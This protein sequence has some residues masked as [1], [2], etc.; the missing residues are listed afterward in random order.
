MPMREAARLMHATGE[1]VFW[2]VTTPTVGTQGDPALGSVGLRVGKTV[3][4]RFHYDA[5]VDGG[6]KN[7]RAGAISGVATDEN[8]D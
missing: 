2:V 7:Q 5:S 3:W 8:S 1:L 4:I 6:P